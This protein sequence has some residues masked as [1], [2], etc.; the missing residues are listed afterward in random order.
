MP[1][2]ELNPPGATPKRRG[3]T[4]RVLVTMRAINPDGCRWRHAHGLI[5]T[6][7]ARFP[8]AGLVTMR[9]SLYPDRQ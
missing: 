7:Q 1:P 5:W 8:G 4:G 3:T 6:E 2:L 9:S